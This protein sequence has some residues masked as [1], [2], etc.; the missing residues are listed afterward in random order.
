MATL[1]PEA[2]EKNLLQWDRAVV[3]YIIGKLPVFTPFLQFLKKKWNPKGEIHLF[4]HGNGFFTVKFDLEE[5]LNSTLEGGPWTMD[6]RPFIIR[7]W[8]PQVHMEQERL[9]S[10]PL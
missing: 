1:N 8:S 7:K 6:H 2:Y 9:S 5:D 3:G 4:L 10:I